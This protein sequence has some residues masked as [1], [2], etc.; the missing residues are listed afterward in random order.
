MDGAAAEGGSMKRALL[1]ICLTIAALPVASAATDDAQLL[2]GHWRMQSLLVDGRRP[3]DAFV[4]AGKLEVQGHRYTVELGGGVEVMTFA[5]DQNRKLRTFDLTMAEGPRKGRTSAG[6]YTLVGDTFTLCR[7]AEP[8][9]RRPAA[10]ASAPG[11]G[12]ILVVW[13]RAR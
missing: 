7:E 3:P 11:S 10:L 12:A 9:G 8:N 6:I 1:A 4:R 5:L 13:R 2:Q